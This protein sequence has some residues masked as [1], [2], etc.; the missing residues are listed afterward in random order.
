MKNKLLTMLMLGAS[1]LLSGCS[2][3]DADL[4]RR[5]QGAWNQRLRSYTNNLTMVPD[6]TFAYSRIGTN[7]ELTFTNA[8]TWRIKGGH[9]VLSA[10]NRIGE[11]P[12]PLG[13]LFNAKIVRLDDRQFEFEMQ[14][15]QNGTFER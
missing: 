6:G 9:I 3:H 7:S 13:E 12:L 10:T 4:A 1:L 8:G 11:H 5:I 2:R 14:E 15:G